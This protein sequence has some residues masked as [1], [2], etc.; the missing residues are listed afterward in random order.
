[1]NL[2]TILTEVRDIIGE[3]TADFWS[4]AELTRH[5]NEGLRRLS[6]ANRWSW[7]LTE[8]TATLVAAS[9]DV[10]LTEGVADYR[11]LNIM[12]TKV[13]DTRPYLPKRVTPARGFQ[14]RTENY[15]AQSY[16]MWFYLTASTNQGTGATIATIRFI[17]ECITD[18]AVEFQYYDVPTALSA[19]ADV[20]DVP[21]QYQKALIHYAAGAAWLKELNGAGKAQEQFSLY[22]TIVAEAFADE[23][24][25]PDD[26]FLIVGGN[27]NG[28]VPGRPLS[29]HDYTLQRIASTLGP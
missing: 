9:T 29:A 20:P 13:G 24:S 25:Q 17:P 2:T 7:L 18:L 23:E 26:S 14:L 19:G 27:D 4:D 8:G 15:T 16:P 22:D 1:V 28:S 3:T 11:H 6:G 10:D 12:L 21:T 5:V